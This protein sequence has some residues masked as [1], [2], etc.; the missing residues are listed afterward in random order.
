MKCTK[1][2]FAIICIVLAVPPS[3]SIGILYYPSRRQN[4][5]PLQALIDFLRTSLKRNVK[6]RKKKAQGSLEAS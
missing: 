2:S 5:A 4:P 1:R 3:L 6:C